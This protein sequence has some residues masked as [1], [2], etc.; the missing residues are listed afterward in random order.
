MLSN[1][2][3]L[4]LSNY[5]D[6]Y[7][8]VIPQ[9]H[10]LR[11]IN[12]MID[13]SFIY[14]ELEN[15]YC[16][17]NGRNAQ[18]PI[19]LFKYLFLKYL[20][21]LSDNGVVERSRYD[22]SFKYFLDMTPEENVI[23]PSLLTKFR[24]LRLKDK[25]LLDMLIAKSVEIAI[26]QGVLKSRTVIV[27]STHTN[28][29]YHKAT[30]IKMLKTA[31]S[32]LKEAI[33]KTCEE[34]DLPTEPAKQSSTDEYQDYCKELLETVQ[35]SPAAEIPA[36]KE[37]SE[38]L[39]EIM[40][41]KVDSYEQSTD[42]DAR[43][44]HKDADKPFYGYKTH[45]AMTEERLITAAAITSGEAFDGKELPS[46]VQ[47][48]KENGVQV[49]EVL[50]DTAYSTLENL[51]NAE[52]HGYKLVSKL[53]PCITKGKRPEDGFV[54]N[55][56]ADTMQCPAGHLAVSKYVDKRNSSKKNTR[57]KYRFD[58]KKCSTCPYREGC[59]KAGAKSKI[60]TVT[61][62]SDYHKKQE[63]FQNTEYFKDRL[64][65]RYMIEAKNSELKN[66]HG[67]DQCD[68]AG[69]DSM[70]LQGAVSIF[71]V[72]IKRILKLKGGVCPF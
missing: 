8:I 69:L 43:V 64:K 65:N 61:I 28:A 14:E 54:F 36:V 32:G 3:G 50:A 58:I 63:D 66:I 11:K 6:I 60:Y 5:S 9:D 52:E 34:S 30:R 53:N 70:Q 45:L 59:Y 4:N 72:N 71:V 24:T 51:Q 39:Q 17:D 10:I 46:L 12:D 27:D 33:Q 22:M 57:I 48:T 19:R 16:L 42:P 40:E 55:K 68:S 37:A 56:D 31:A 15:K 35:E 62:K 2:L 49:E 25:N 44:G 38:L 7:D 41:N 67:Y 1:Q 18:S 29:R 26:E 21:N 13:F 20:Y 47:K 23:H